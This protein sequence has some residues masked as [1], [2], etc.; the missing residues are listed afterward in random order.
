MYALKEKTSGLYLDI[1]TLG[2]HESG[3]TTNSISLNANPCVIYFEEG[4]NGTWKLKNINGTYAS[5]VTSERNWNTTI[6]STAYEWKI[7]EADGLI[8]IAKNANN[9]I[10][11]DK[12]KAIIAGSALYNNAEGDNKEAERISFSLVEYTSANLSQGYY[13]LKS[14]T[15]TYFNFTPHNILGTAATFQ[16]TPSYLKI[17][18]SVN[19]LIFE[20]K[21]EQGKYISTEGSAWN[22]TTSAPT[23]WEFNNV[24]ETGFG[25]I[26]RYGV[27]SETKSLG[28]DDS[29]INA[30]TGIFTN[31]SNTGC[32]KW[33]IT[34]IFDYPTV[35]TT[36]NEKIEFTSGK[37]YYYNPC[38]TIR[39]TLT[40]SDAF[41]K[42]GAKRMSLDE[43]YLY[44]ANGAEV[45]LDASNVVGNNCMTFKGMFDRTDGTYAGTKTGN[46]EDF[47]YIFKFVYAP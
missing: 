42:N 11:W 2:I 28:S 8:T 19:I 12:N 5:N 17:I 27:T 29:N 4:A 15:G 25:L 16:D 14:A 13:S 6:S 30:G 44:D 31:V 40:E 46:S 7:A 32:Y 34:G 24:D 38:N 45:K 39:F 9:Y 43:F 36:N 18:P 10:G 33:Y 23:L 37:I 26:Q 47:I 20:D 41:F 22:V 1:Q 35:G 3:Y 21:D